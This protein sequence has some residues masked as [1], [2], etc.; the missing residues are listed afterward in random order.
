MSF[1]FNVLGYKVGVGL[2]NPATWQFLNLTVNVVQRPV[3]VSVSVNVLGVAAA[4]EVVKVVTDD[5]ST[6]Q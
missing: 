6:A 5:A 4:V 1:S 3:I 2:S